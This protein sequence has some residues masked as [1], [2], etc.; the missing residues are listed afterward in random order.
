MYERSFLG[1]TNQANFEGFALYRALLR[2]IRKLPPTQIP[3][4][5]V[6]ITCRKLS[7]TFRK[8]ARLQSPKDM[9]EALQQGYVVNSADLLVNRPMQC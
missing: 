8:N 9:V 6:S 2:Y 3:L 7:H 5:P 4:A 1:P